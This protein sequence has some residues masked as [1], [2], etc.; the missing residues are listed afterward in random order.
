M[1]PCAHDDLRHARR[2]IRAN[3]ATASCIRETRC[4]RT[5]SKCTTALSG[6]NAQARRPYTSRG[7]RHTQASGH[8]RDTNASA[9]RDNKHCIK[10]GGM[11]ACRRRGHGKARDTLGVPDAHGR[12]AWQQCSGGGA[13]MHAQR[14]TPC[15]RYSRSSRAPHAVHNLQTQPYQ[16]TGPRS[17]SSKAPCFSRSSNT[18]WRLPQ[19]ATLEHH[20]A[21]YT[22]TATHDAG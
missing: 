8:V 11:R 19:G 15:T 3:A 2:G 17:P 4:S 12:A 7:A 14:H 6:R 21:L 18:S 9:R 16:H 1:H 10:R 5:W 13:C 20:S 22:V